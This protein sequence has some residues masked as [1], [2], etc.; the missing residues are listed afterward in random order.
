M[1][2]KLLIAFGCFFILGIWKVD[3]QAPG[4]DFSAT[5]T[6]GCS[7]L[8]VQF[9]DIS[10]NGPTAW[11]WDFGN[12]QTSNQQNPY[13]SYSSP[14]T[15]TVTLISRNASGANAM[16]KVG[17]ITVSPSPSVSFTSTLNVACAPATVQLFDHS[18]P[19]T[20]GIVSWSWGFGDGATSS[21]QNPAHV[22]TQTG[23]Y[24]VTLKVVNTNGCSTTSNAP[25]FIRVVDGIQPNF[26]YN[27][28]STSCTAPFTANFLNQT[29]GPGT[30]TY[31]WSLGSGATPA[32]STDANPAGIVYPTAN[33]YTIS[34][35]VQ[36]S[37]GCSQ[38]FQKTISFS[39]FTASFDG[40]SAIC[41]NN[42]A[43]FTNTS[44][45]TPL[46][47]AWD[48]GNGSSS[49]ANP[50]TQTYTATGNY[51]VKLV[52]KYAGCVDSITKPLSAV[53]APTVDFIADLTTACKPD[54][55]VH[56]T[57]RST[58][59]STSWLWDFGDGQTSTAQDPI[60][61]YKS[62]GTF[63]VKLTVTGAGGCPGSTTKSGFITLKAPVAS[64]VNAGN[65][66][67]CVT[68]SP[69][70]TTVTPTVTIDGVDLPST[71]NWQAPGSNEISSTSATP[72]F[73]YNNPI[74]YTITVSVTTT[75]GCTATASSSVAIGTPTASD[76]TMNS[77][78][79][80]TSVCG[81]DSVTFTAAPS[82]TYSYIWDFGDGTISKPQT[83]NTIKY[84]YNKAY[85]P[86]TVTL[87]LINH[88]CPTKIPHQLTVNPPF[89]NFGYR[90]DCST[91]PKSVIFTDSTLPGASNYIWG[92]DDGS[93][94]SEPP[95]VSPPYAPAPGVHPVTLTVSQGACVTQSYTKPVTILQVNPSFSIRVGELTTAPPISV[96]KNL[97][98]QLRSTTSV[99]PGVVAADSYI[100]Q[101]TWQV[102][103]NPPEITTDP[104]HDVVLTPNGP[105]TIQLSMIDTN[106]CPEIAPNINVNAV[107]PTASFTP[108]PLVGACKNSPV[109]LTSTSVSGPAPAITNST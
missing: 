98:I 62:I 82:G 46:S 5:P 26:T 9:K 39:N 6:S 25:R 42:P 55:T 58:A 77:P 68:G 78:S 15:Y 87:S 48:F 22:Y 94:A 106:G 108:T 63:D 57:D 35:Q 19:G 53:T 79:G 52:N 102:D 69:S 71:Y 27:Q 100:K 83:Q 4:T 107:G 40:P 81:R 31:N 18:T 103:A 7:P 14:G 49:S 84:A 23:Y 51:N 36:S 101:Y 91:S 80:A 67:A 104:E 73:T 66:G 85:S 34:L 45:P 88:G 2:R 72:S 64:I 99:T 24:T 90:I 21:D 16:R 59:G 10:S 41:I 32:S 97:P 70:Y 54:L 93:T 11:S 33:P 1:N 47:S 50:G 3:A 20:G 61:V 8:V 74:D 13:I 75:G 17:F 30:L 76:F 89:P 60:H 105:H 109:A 65:L 28:V 96:C 92:F 29:S 12:G 44:T 37:L 95:A 86:A 56:F 38:S 43:T